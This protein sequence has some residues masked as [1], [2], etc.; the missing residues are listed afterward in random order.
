MLIDS[1]K[2]RDTIH[3]CFRCGYCKFPTTWADVN[4]CPPYARFRMEPYSCGGRLWVTR[5]WL[6]EKLKWSDHLA[7]ILYSCTTCRNC[8]IKCPLSFNVDIVNMVIAARSEM[9]EQ[10]KV[11]AAVRKF[12]E[13]TDLYGNPYGISRSKRSAWME[14][15]GL[16]QYDRH[17]FLYYVGCTGS[18]DT[19]AQNA[20][21][22]V[23]RALRAAGVSV[24]VL[25]NDENCDGNE[26]HKLGE[27]GLFEVLAEETIG[28]CRKLG[29][30]KV[31]TLSPHAYHAFRNLYPR[32]GAEFEVYHYT[33]VLYKAVREGALNVSRGFG[34]TVTYHDPCFLGRWND[35][36]EAPRR[37]L[38]ATPSVRFLE[39]P[40]NRDAALCCGGG[41]GNFEIDLLGGSGSSPARRRVREAV[42]AGAQVL[43]VACPKCLVMLED[44]VKAEDAGDR[45]AVKD[46]AEIVC[47]ACGTE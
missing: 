5:A 13:N 27:E 12:L 20:A 21:R 46:I 25:G 23:G 44:A 17:E 42:E 1:Y 9:V 47:A 29:V 10:G 41:A 14:G 33:Q 40:K 43:A 22:A 38:A 15:E 18:Y 35:E 7:E 30:T 19:R 39:M 24:G 45:I 8:E 28:R 2:F 16:E 11:P 4:N 36:Y 26:V 31:V 6:N 37:L 32:F 3:R 34:A